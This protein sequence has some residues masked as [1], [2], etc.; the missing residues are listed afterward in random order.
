MNDKKTIAK[1]ILKREPTIAQEIVSQYMANLAKK[2]KAQ[3][4]VAQQEASRL[5]GKL[6]GRPRK[7]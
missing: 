3:N 1:Q 2:S 5:N 6:G 7:K 4:T